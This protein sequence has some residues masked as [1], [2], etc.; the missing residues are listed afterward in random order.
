MKNITMENATETTTKVS[1]ESTEIIASGIADF[2]VSLLI[3]M[4]ENDSDAN[5]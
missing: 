3:G 4:L 2:M 5:G 1:T